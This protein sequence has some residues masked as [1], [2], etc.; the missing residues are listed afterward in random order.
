MVIF[1]KSCPKT[2]IILF[3]PVYHITHHQNPLRQ[4]QTRSDIEDNLFIY[5]TASQ[6]A[7]KRRNMILQLAYIFRPDDRRN[8]VKPAKRLNSG[9][10]SRKYILTAADRIQQIRQISRIPAVE[11]GTESR[12]DIQAY[13]QTGTV[14]R[15]FPSKS[16]SERSLPAAADRRID[17]PESGAA[18]ASLFS[19]R[20]LQA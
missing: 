6:S 2:R 9:C 19:L 15:K 18:R 12:T 14:L 1:K 4:R 13:K 16:K 8:I 20:L 7:Q 11:K 5:P 17:P 3:W 10:K